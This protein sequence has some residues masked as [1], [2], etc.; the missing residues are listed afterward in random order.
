MFLEGENTQRHKYQQPTTTTTT[1]ND[2][3]RAPKTDIQ[4]SN[5]TPTPTPTERGPDQKGREEKKGKGHRTDLDAAVGKV[6][7]ER[8]Q[9]GGHPR[10]DVQAGLPCLCLCHVMLQWVMFGH[11]GV[12]G[13]FGGLLKVY[14]G[15][16]GFG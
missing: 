10:V 11:V 16:K 1:T 15:G 6:C 2:N 9:E 12:G 7:V 14:A 4:Q 3:G 13:L 8:G 5:P